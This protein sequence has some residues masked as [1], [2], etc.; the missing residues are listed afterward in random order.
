M[1]LTT[2]IMSQI[3]IFSNSVAS[4]SKPPTVLILI[5]EDQR[6]WCEQFSQEGY[7]VVQIVYP[8]PPGTSF[9]ETLK[10]AEEKI[11]AF[12]A[13]WGLISYGLA[14]KDAELLLSR[15][16]LSI[17][18][19]KACVHFCP[20]ADGSR[21]FLAKD[22]QSRYVPVAFHLATS[23]EAFHAAVLP[24]EDPANL[25]YVL[26]THSNHPIKV[27]T[28]PLVSRLPPFPFLSKAPVQAKPGEPSSTDISNRSATSLSLTRTLELLK[29]HLGPHFNLEKLWEMH[30]YYEF[31]ERDAPK[32]MKTMVPSPYV[33]H[34]ATMTGGVG[35]EDL[36][37]FYKYHFTKSTMQ[38]TP[39]DSEL[40][41][42]SRT[43]GV[44]RIVDE[45]I[46]KCHHTTEIDY[47]LPGVAP[48]G[49]YVEIALV[50]IVAF[51]GDKL[52]FEHLYWDQA[53]V[54]VQLGLMERSNLPI[55]GVEVAQKVVD[56]FG[57]PS[58]GL[59]GRWG[60]SEGL[61]ID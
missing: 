37:R 55:A 13:D 15:L 23:Q 22:N 33:N 18:D 38:V 48:T 43:V 4:V 21:G 31:V 39:P 5:H 17:A 47:F 7:N 52:F 42:V 51:R 41:V 27:Y 28:Y 14:T 20:D 6:G 56:P 40:V 54:L 29:S 1:H 16:A 60:E 11:I 53:S 24:L 35:Y 10:V 49:R 46:F 2:S 3:N 30:T 12:G 57:L 44:D 8:P 59:L 45:M 25:G 58:N 61:S 32:T 34:V 36:A 26:P 19:L 9:K 50:G